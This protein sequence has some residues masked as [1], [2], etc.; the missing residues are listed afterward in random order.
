VTP[1]FQWDEPLEVDAGRTCD[2]DF[3]LYQPNKKPAAIA[4]NAA[5]RF[6]LSAAADDDTPLLDIDSIAALAGG[7]II[8]ILSRG[9]QDV[10]PASVRV[11]FAQA[12]TQLIEAGADYVGELGVVDASETSPLNAFKRAGYGPVTIKASPGGDVGLT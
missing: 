4:N 5:V 3:A 11:R 10:T 7:S 2:Y 1:T 8:T 9:V 6:K 12:D